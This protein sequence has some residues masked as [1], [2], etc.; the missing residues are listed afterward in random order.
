[1]ATKERYIITGISVQL[2]VLQEKKGNSYSPS[3][4]SWMKNLFFFLSFPVSYVMRYF[5]FLSIFDVPPRLA[6]FSF[7]DLFLFS[8]FSLKIWHG[9]RTYHSSHLPKSDIETTK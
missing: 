2:T 1:M 3:F 6:S 8:M 5:E 4:P 9:S 7:E